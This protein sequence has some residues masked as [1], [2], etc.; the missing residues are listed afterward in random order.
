MAVKLNQY[1]TN[2]KIKGHLLSN[3]KMKEIGF[4][5]NYYEGTEFEQRS[6]Y[7]WFKKGFN[8]PKKFKDVGWSL[9]FTCKIYKDTREVRIDVLDMDFGQ[10]F[11][12]QILLEKNP[13]NELALAVKEQVEEHM[14]YLQDEKVISGHKYGEYI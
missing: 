13:E 1:G 4:N 3:A 10:V 2:A 8:L 9:E 5:L 7:V 12:Y 11:D 14:K 6:D